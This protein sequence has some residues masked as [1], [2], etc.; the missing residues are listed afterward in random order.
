MIELVVGRPALLVIDMQ[1]DFVDAEASCYNVGAEATV[2][3][4]ARAVA[5][6]RDAGL[7][8]VW[9]MEAHRPGGVDAGLENS[10]D[11]T[12][13][14][15]TVEGTPGIEIVPELAPG[16]EDLV[17]RKRRYNCFLGTELDLLLKALRVDTL[18]VGGVSSDVC[19]H[20]TVG[21]AFQRDFHVRVLEDCVAGTSIADHEASLLIMRNLV[22][23]GQR[24]AS[25]DLIGA[26]AGDV[27]VA[28]GA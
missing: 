2:A 15:H 16:P 10:P 18:L 27:A 22:S 28:S 8:V 3:P 12:F 9:T 1:H 24:F 19:V 21:E 25:G 13:G 4:L 14:A 5:A 7:P 23:A 20:W 26:L 6:M 11:C 17:V